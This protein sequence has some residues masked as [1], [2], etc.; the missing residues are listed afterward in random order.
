MKLCT[1]RLTMAVAI[2]SAYM[3]SAVYAQETVS[4]AE[5]DAQVNAAQADQVQS[6][7]SAKLS[8]AAAASAASKSEGIQTVV[9]TA[10]KRKED[11]SKVP[12]SIS[13]IGGDELT[14]QHIGDYADI[15]RAI[16]NISFSGGGGGGDAGDGPGLSNIEIRGISSSAG[17]ATVG[18]Y[19]D[20]VSLNVANEYSMGS[21]EPK[22][23]DLDH[24]EVL[25]GPQGT[26][27]G[28]SSMGG[29]IKF[30]TNQPDTKQQ[31][32]DIYTEFSSW[33]GGEGS[34]T[35]NVVFNEPLI[36]N[37]LALRFGVQGGHQ[38][39]YINQVDQSG[40]VTNY[41]I[42][43]QD[44]QVIHFAMKWTPTKDLTITPNVIYQKV[45]TGDTDVSY[46][47][48]LNN[49]V[50]LAAPVALPPY[51][52]SKTTREPGAD[53]LLVPSVTVNYDAGTVGDITSVTSLFKRT[54]N[55][56]QDGG[57][58]DSRQLE[59]AIANPTLGAAVGELPASV[60]LNNDV[61]Q[62]SQEIRLASKPY[63]KG[64]SPVT[65]IV[66]A[67]VANEHTN[68]TEND[69]V[70]GINSTF[71]AFGVSTTDQTQFNPGYV[72]TGF[73]GD[74]TFD[75]SYRSHD[76]Q[77]SVFGE[78]SYYFTPELHA[79]VGIRYLRAQE[80]FTAQQSGFY[81][82]AL[83][84]PTL[85]S[86]ANSSKTTPKFSVIWEQSPSN[87]IFATAQEG[88]RVGGAN[89][90]IPNY[91]FS[92]T[93]QAGV[94][95]IPPFTPDS[96]WSYELGDKSRFL[97][98][99]L[100][101]NASLFYVK[102][103]NMQQE[104]QLGCDFNYDANVGS[105]TS[106]GAELEVK[107]KPISSLLLDLAAGYTHATLDNSE[108]AESGVVGAVAGAAIPG[109][110]AYNIAFTSTYSYDITDDYFGFL[111]GAARWTGASHGGF[112]Q[113]PNG[114]GVLIAPNI[115]P[116]IPDPDLNRPAYHT[117]DLSTGVSWKE[118]EATVF[119]KNLFNNDMVIQRPITQQVEGE[120][121][122][123]EPR[124]IGASLSAKF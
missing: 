113:L 67:Y 20:D 89:N 24:V 25:R 32:T 83:T 118:W 116:G 52:T 15:T 98:N 35:G 75:G 37:E 3:A 121:Y 96:I 57:Q 28:A 26:L 114:N 12:V 71:N 61:E 58:A 1:K 102:W 10:Q 4:S 11:S 76:T 69:P 79:T 115:L 22:F 53:K 47:Q 72:A 93:A 63:V 78:S 31:T 84:G 100:T 34:Y 6:A 68:I 120:V 51:E 2:A 97:N 49:G 119:V 110:P 13:V 87:S 77:Q 80:E 90:A 41:G 54:F 59:V 92:S 17:S 64:G 109:V 104:I 62:F 38:G 88:F 117:I 48:I 19:M 36:Q 123:L 85:T 124:M 111:R 91:C 81:Y 23:F 74:N 27:Y 107:A 39:G 44:N 73:P 43:W 8:G 86:D 95:T 46:S 30:V 106:Y 60:L 99:K 7:D 50:P 5:T 94:T 70:Y 101:V 108:G 16:P 33:K 56:T 65:W 40:N 9:V 66:G 82:G 112:D 21:A 29:T 105:A 45:S 55:R 18:I 122:R 103:K 42:N 14:A